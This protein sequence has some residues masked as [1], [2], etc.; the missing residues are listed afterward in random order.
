MFL[1]NDR[2]DLAL[3]CNADGVHLGQDDLSVNEARKITPEGFIIGLSTHLP[4]QGKNAVVAIHELPPDYLGVGP[5][6][7]TP[8]KPDYKAAGLE[9]VSWAKDNLK[10]IPWFA[11]GGIDGDNIDK[12][13]NAGGASVAVVRAIMYSNDPKSVTKK[14]KERLLEREYV[15]SK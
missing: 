11:I 15:E 13:I 14:L 4:E 12:V 5:V 3:A 8:T 1:I 10:N 9:Y 6:F 7:P 2:L